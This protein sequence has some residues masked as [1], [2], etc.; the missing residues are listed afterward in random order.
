MDELDAMAERLALETGPMPGL[1]DA[2]YSVTPSQPLVRTVHW[3]GRMGIDISG[4]WCFGLQ[5]LEGKSETQ[6]RELMQQRHNML[7]CDMLD[8]L[9][10]KLIP[11]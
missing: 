1:F 9:M 8:Y 10:S 2:S 4:N 11:V 7:C 5:E 6:I 3:R